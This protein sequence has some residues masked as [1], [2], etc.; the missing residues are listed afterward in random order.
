M[1]TKYNSSK[2]ELI[3]TIKITWLYRCIQLK[4]KQE[5]EAGI[6]FDSVYS[7]DPDFKYKILKDQEINIILPFWDIL[8]LDDK[9]ILKNYLQARYEKLEFKKLQNKLKD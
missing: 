9:M 5:I 6:I 2:F 7:L 3:K 1:L 8:F 4:A